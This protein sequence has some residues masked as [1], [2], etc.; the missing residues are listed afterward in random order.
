MSPLC[1]GFR[2]WS[3][4]CTISL[5]YLLIYHCCCCVTCDCWCQ[6]TGPQRPVLCC[7]L[8]L[9]C[10]TYTRRKVLF[11][12]IWRRT[13]SCLMKMT[14]SLSVSV[15]STVIVKDPNLP[16]SRRLFVPHLLHMKARNSTQKCTRMH[17][18]QRQYS[19]NFIWRD[20]APLNSLPHWEREPC[21]LYHAPLFWCMSPSPSHHLLPTVSAVLSHV[22]TK[23]P[24]FVTIC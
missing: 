6:P 19:N 4:R 13:T 22:A 1:K 3:L 7:R 11:I 12:A 9:L 20:A 24:L 16:L 2:W 10:A 8:S 21:L 17:H 15:L 18:F 23:E 14:K 5:C